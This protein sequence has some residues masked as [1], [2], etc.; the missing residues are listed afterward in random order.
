MPELDTAVSEH[1]QRR[2]LRFGE[3]CDVDAKV[4]ASTG[5]YSQFAVLHRGDQ[6]RGLRGLAELVCPCCKGIREQCRHRNRYAGRNALQ[7]LGIPCELQ[8]G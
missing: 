7:L 4:G 6:Q 5:H 8:Q 3:Y 1:H 2:L